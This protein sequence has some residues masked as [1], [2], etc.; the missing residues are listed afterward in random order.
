MS[1]AL[2]PPLRGKPTFLRKCFALWVR[3]R[4]HVIMSYSYFGRVTGGLRSESWG[5]HRQHCGYVSIS[6]WC[7]FLFVGWFSCGIHLQ[8]IGSLTIESILSLFRESVPAVIIRPFWRTYSQCSSRSLFTYSG[9]NFISRD[10]IWYFHKSHFGGSSTSSFFRSRNCSCYK[11]SFL[12]CSLISPHTVQYCSL[13][14]GQI[15]YRVYST[16]RAS[17]S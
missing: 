12:C 9:R 5:C 14:R 1:A 17:D 10:S 3:R 16:I 13:Y 2:V 8:S 11:H 7:E 15:L 4:L 6:P